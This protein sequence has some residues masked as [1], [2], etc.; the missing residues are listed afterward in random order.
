MSAG[1][2]ARL[3]SPVAQRADFS[4]VLGDGWTSALATTMAQRPVYLERDG[5]VSLG[6]L[7]EITGTPGASIR[8][9]GDLGTAD[10]VGAG[11]NGGQVVIEGDVGVEA[12]MA[13]SGGVLDVEGDAGERAGAAP[14]GYQRGMTG[15]ELIIRGSAGAEAGARMRRGLLVIGRSAGDRTGL[16]MLAG[17]IIVLGSAGT[18]VGLWSKRGSVVGLGAITPPPTYSFACTYQPIHLRLILTRLRDRHRLS[19]RRRHFT[20]LYHRYSGDFAELGKG[21]ILVWTAH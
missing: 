16:G 6:D 14:L 5:R 2:V 1:L 21:E 11:L 7:F 8:F 3:R 18:D 20:G 10:R 4:E 19:I 12:G 17:N 15:G 13:M 9:A